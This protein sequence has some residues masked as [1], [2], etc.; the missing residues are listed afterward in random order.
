M[1]SLLH[2]DS[3]GCLGHGHETSSSNSGHGHGH[4][5]GHGNGNLGHGHVHGVQEK[6]MSLAEA[7]TDAE[8]YQAPE[9]PQAFSQSVQWLMVHDPA[10]CNFHTNNTGFD[11]QCTEARC[12]HTELNSTQNVIVIVRA[13]ELASMSRVNTALAFLSV[14]YIAV[15]VICIILNSYDNDCDPSKDQSCDP[16]T[17]PPVFHLLEFWATFMFNTVDL[18]AISYSPKKLSNQYEHP[19]LLKLLVLFNIGL[20]FCSSLLVSIN[21]EKFEV[22]A[23]EFEYLNELTITLFDITIFLALLRGRSHEVNRQSDAKRVSLIG[24]LAVGCIAVLQLGVYNLCG[25]T[26][27]GDSNGEQAAHYLEFTFGIVSA[28]ITF[29]FTMDNRISADKRLRALMYGRTALMS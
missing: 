3:C 20:S 29:W 23:H 18:L 9:S 14:L 27:D 24:L 22:L 2:N 13:N 10:E 17:T 4:G 16:A 8:D 26:A 5:H 6:E 19:N 11:R 1:A 28:G 25:W 12:D 15:Q 7:P 21:L